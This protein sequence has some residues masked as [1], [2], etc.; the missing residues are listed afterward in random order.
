MEGRIVKDNLEDFGRKLLW[1]TFLGVSEE[2]HEESIML[3]K[4]LAVTFKTGASPGQLQ[5]IIR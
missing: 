2:N 3:N 4:V 5:H 1:R